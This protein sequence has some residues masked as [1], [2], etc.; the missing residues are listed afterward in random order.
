M[1]P[2]PD[3][4]RSPDA[5]AR[6]AEAARRRLIRRALARLWRRLRA[7]LARAFVR[8]RAEAGLRAL[9]ERAL[10]DLGLDRGGIAHAARHGRRERG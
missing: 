3:P 1:T 5:L 7:R 8:A 9:D 6:H 10:R 2:L 4:F